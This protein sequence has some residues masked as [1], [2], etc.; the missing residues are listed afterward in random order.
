MDRARLPYR[1]RGHDDDRA[2][3]RLE[4]GEQWNADQDTV[5]SKGSVARFAPIAALA[6]VLIAA[7]ASAFSMLIWEPAADPPA[8]ATPTVASGQ[9]GRVQ[10][11]QARRVEEFADGWEGKT[12]CSVL[13]VLLDPLGA[14]SAPACCEAGASIAS[15]RWLG[16][17][18]GR[19]PPRAAPRGVARGGPGLCLSGP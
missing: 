5:R 12:R 14:L 2:Y 3:N 8:A 10:S 9:S 4:G 16:R 7:C 6:V 17:R 19:V 11:G 13:T 15:P 18:A 1:R